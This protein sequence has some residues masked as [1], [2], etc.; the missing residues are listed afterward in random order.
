MIFQN[1]EVTPL[2]NAQLSINQQGNLLIS[3]IG[4]SGLDG[5][6]I[7][8]N[9]NDSIHAFLEPIDLENGGTL[10]VVS[11]GKNSLNQVATRSETVTW[12]DTITNRVQFGYNMGLIPKHYSIIGNLNGNPVFDIPMDNPYNEDPPPPD[13]QPCFWAALAAIAAAVTAAVAV[14]KLIAGTEETTIKET[15]HPDGSKTVET[16]KKTDPTPIE[17]FV[18]GQSYV[19]DEWGIKY[20]ETIPAIHTDKIMTI[21]ALQITGYNLGNLVITSITT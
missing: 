18:N 11:I 16:T 12:L 21:A 13:P 1:Y 19:V 14:Y 3:N 9:S 4:V 8:N 10:R 2:G 7:K 15:V 17:V 20:S 5:V 6:M